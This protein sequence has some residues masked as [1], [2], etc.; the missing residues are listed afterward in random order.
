MR[1]VL[2]I[3]DDIDDGGLF[4]EALEE[5]DASTHL[6]FFDDGKAA[7]LA[8]ANGHVLLPEVIFLDINMPSING[9]DCLH[10]IKKINSLANTPVI[11]YTTSSTSHEKVKANNLGAAGLITKPDDYNQLKDIIATVLA[12]PV[13]DLSQALHKL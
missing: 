13:H 4:R 10:E 3:D 8:L 1:K 12:T 6:D 7:L 2:L 11:I 5:V 9:W